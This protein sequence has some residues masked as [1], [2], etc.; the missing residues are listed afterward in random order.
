MYYIKANEE[1]QKHF[2]IPKTRKLE[3]LPG[4]SKK[5]TLGFLSK[6]S[7]NLLAFWKGPFCLDFREILSE[8]YKNPGKSWKFDFILHP[9]CRK[10]RN[11]LFLHFGQFS[12]MFWVHWG[13][14]RWNCPSL[15][16][17][18][19]GRGIVRRPGSPEN[20]GG[21]KVPGSIL[22]TAPPSSPSCLILIMMSMR[23]I[24]WMMK[25]RMRMNFRMI[26]NKDD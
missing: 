14:L 25:M 13:D 20:A 22:V 6:K 8:T 15:K 1:I 21:E 24:M 4:R 2:W 16:N 11:F 17:L 9:F 19:G 12:A 5:C 26:K 18:P 7:W 3:Q 10:S 23:G